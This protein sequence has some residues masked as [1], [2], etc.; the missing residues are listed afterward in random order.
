M[1][2]ILI[3]GLIALMH[4]IRKD[5]ETSTLTFAASALAA[6]VVTFAL[7]FLPRARSR[8][9]PVAGMSLSTALV[10]AL[11]FTANGLFGGAD[12]T[13]LQWIAAVAVGALSG[14]GMGALV[15]WLGRLLR[16]RDSLAA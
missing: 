13:P 8:R 11:L 10:G 9:L 4:W 3:A 14:A 1:S 2:G 5:G 7:E 16:R 15:G 6:A 12:W